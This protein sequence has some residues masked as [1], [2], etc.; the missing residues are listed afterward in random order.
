MT[1]DQLKKEFEK[2]VFI[3]SSSLVKRKGNQAS[4]D[5]G[6]EVKNYALKYADKI[7]GLRGDIELE[8]AEAIAVTQENIWKKLLTHDISVEGELNNPSAFW[9]RHFTHHIRFY[10]LKRLARRSTKKTVEQYKKEVADS[11]D[12]NQPTRYRGG[13]FETFDDKHQ[14]ALSEDFV[15]PDISKG[16][17]VELLIGKGIKIEVIE[18]LL[19]R[20]S[21]LKYAQIA[22]QLCI[23]KDEARMKFERA[24]KDHGLDKTLLIT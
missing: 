12:I 16:D 18:V 24:T 13:R 4:N 6:L 22:E 19:L 2:F 17:I 14:D 15:E 5:T 20:A 8:A 23:T 11:N 1:N 21:G 7:L 9:M 3:Q 10:L